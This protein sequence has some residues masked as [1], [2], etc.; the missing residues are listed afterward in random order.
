LFQDEYNVEPSINHVETTVVGG[1][2]YYLVRISNKP[3]CLDLLSL[4]KYG[5][6]EWTVPQGLSSMLLK[7]WIKC[8]FDCEAHI[9]KSRNHIQV[10]SVNGK[11]LNQIK[12][13]LCE[14]DI[15]GRVY[16]P[17]ANGPGHNPYFMLS[18]YL[19]SEVIKYRD[20]IG[21][22]HSKKNKILQSL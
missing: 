14:Q 16:G 4:G 20:T 12:E 8:F 7:E 18:I 5:K 22:Y 17:Y 11:G 13:I 21:F 1:K 2:G 9:N 3:V 15:L 6:L 19:L 10:K